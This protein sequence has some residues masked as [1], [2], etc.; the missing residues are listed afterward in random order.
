MF[1]LGFLFVAFFKLFDCEFNT[2]YVSTIINNTYSTNSIEPP[3][4]LPKKSFK[5]SFIV[6]LYL[7]MLKKLDRWLKTKPSWVSI[8]LGLLFFWIIKFIIW[9]YISEYF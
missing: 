4:I 1:P 9:P 3:T 5:S 8:L 7:N 6:C 2:F